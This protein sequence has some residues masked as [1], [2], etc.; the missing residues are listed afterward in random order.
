MISSSKSNPN[1]KKLKNHR[2]M[3]KIMNRSKHK[4]PL[5]PPSKSNFRKSTCNLV[6]NM[7]GLKIAN[8]I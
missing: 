8:S 2:K 5:G 3:K 7:S 6:S 1:N 4:V